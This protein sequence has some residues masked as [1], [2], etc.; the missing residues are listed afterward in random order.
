MRVKDFKT[1]TFREL[2]IKLEKIRDIR[3]LDWLLHDACFALDEIR[4]SRKRF[5]IPI[6]R[7]TGEW[8][9][10]GISVDGYVTGELILY[11]V[12]R[13]CDWQ[14]TLSGEWL[15]HQEKLKKIDIISAELSKKSDENEDRPEGFKGETWYHFRLELYNHMLPCY[16]DVLLRGWTD[17][18]L[19]CYRNTGIPCGLDGKLLTP[20]PGGRQ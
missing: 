17:F 11:P 3:I 19:I 6:L 9:Q 8:Q 7:C 20:S 18:P 10:D 16:L 1:T 14:I 4:H 12:L 2:D 15:N 13:L 5:V